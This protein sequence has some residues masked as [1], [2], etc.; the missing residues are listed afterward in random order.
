M[1]P[2]PNGPNQQYPQHYQQ[3]YPPQQPKKSSA[4]VLIAAA[5]VVVA[6]G[7]AGMSQTPS[8]GTSNGATPQVPAAATP[9]ASPSAVAPVVAEEAPR[10]CAVFATGNPNNT[11][12]DREGYASGFAGMRSSGAVGTWTAVEPRTLVVRGLAA[13]DRANMWSAIP[14]GMIN[15]FRVT[16]TAYGFHTVRC[17][18]TT[19]PARTWN[20]MDACPCSDPSLRETC[21]CEF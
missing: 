13:C 14:Q 9:S 4:G 17:E 19:G 21:R 18:P 8:E 11:P 16:C 5:V 15:T 7:I 20:L 12:T 3:P 10:G 2:G 6:I 1:Y